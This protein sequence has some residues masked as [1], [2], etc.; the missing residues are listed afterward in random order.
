MKSYQFH[1]LLLLRSPAY[2]YKSYREAMLQSH[3]DQPYFRNALFLAAPGFYNQLEKQG[4]NIA[5]LKPKAIRTLFNYL[6]RI[7]FRT[8]PFGLF[9]GFAA[10]RWQTEE[11]EPSPISWTGRKLYL[12]DEVKYRQHPGN[13]DSGNL[14]LFANPS[15]YPSGSAFRY[16]KKTYN[17]EKNVLEYSIASM[18]GHELTNAVLDFCRQ[19]R[20]MA[21]ILGQFRQHAQEALTDYI[22]QLLDEDVLVSS[23]R[24]RVLHPSSP[25]QET[26]DD[27][28][29]LTTAISKGQ[30]SYYA[31]LKFEGVTGTAPLQFQQHLRQGLDALQVLCPDLAPDGLRKFRADFLKKF[32]ERSV[33]LMVALDPELGIGYRKLEQ[34]FIQPF[35]LD[36]LELP[37]QAATKHKELQWSRVHAMLLEK[38]QLSTDIRTAGIRLEEADLAGFDI[39]SQTIAPGFSALFRPM[40]NAVFIETAGGATATALL[41]RFGLFDE[42]VGNALQAISDNEVRNNP[43][44]VFAE[45]N[46]VQELHAAN[47]EQRKICYPYEI[48]VAS[49]P[50]GPAGGVIALS[51]LWVSVRG[52]RIL[53]WSEKLDREVIPRLSSAY[54]HSRS[55]LSVYRFLCDLQYQGLRTHFSFDL[56]HYF[57][58]LR[59][60]P[61]VTYKNAILSPATWMP[62]QAA[63]DVISAAPPKE[64][65]ALLGAYLES[66][67]LPVWIGLGRGD[68]QIV[69]DRTC[70]GD[71]ELLLE[72]LGKTNEPVFREFPFIEAGSWVSDRAGNRFL[73]Q[74]LGTLFTPEQ[75]YPAVAY[76]HDIHKALYDKQREDSNWIYLKV[77]CHPGNCFEILKTV[78]ALI[79]EKLCRDLLIS[80]FFYVI[81]QDPGY[82]L[83]LRM[84]SNSDRARASS[85]LLLEDAL[86]PLYQNGMIAQMQMDTYQKEL[87][88][89]G[90]GNMELVEAVFSA[91]TFWIMD[92][93]HYNLI[94]PEPEF[95]KVVASVSLIL[96]AFGLD[97]AA[98]QSFCGQV[99]ESLFEEFGGGKALILSLNEKYRTLRPRLAT[100]LAPVS[101][102]LQELATYQE[103]S[104]CIMALVHHN[105]LSLERPAEALCA[106]IVHMHL[107]R[108][109]SE[110]PR[111]QEMVCY[112]LLQ[113]QL[114]R[115]LH[116]Q[117][118]C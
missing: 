32:E 85:L 44:V 65:P 3:L 43:G 95:V 11:E 16:L 50:A 17:A 78:A 64:G 107:N 29:L 117:A 100:E 82:H 23:A 7:C 109:F 71:L 94:A 1:P 83:R 110:R 42:A 101:G 91:D 114:K 19:P 89:Y 26:M 5:S 33:P 99:F 14:Q 80:R 22:D 68:Q 108:L 15:I 10:V 87:E 25:E 76:R 97:T 2:P 79:T 28:T 98:Q 57:P 104:G 54:N 81:Y 35:L 115:R 40:D 47:V 72:A 69:Y 41:G 12:M 18:A 9:A 84:H 66:L 51:D 74:Y 63:L 75:R 116:Q 39:G 105:N 4:F 31:N 13:T 34:P 38:M 24:I 62:E 52:N 60:Y 90:A 118:A 92:G 27:R 37:A 21:A 49:F 30:Q 93:L 8:T 53:L 86:R 77:Y 45:I 36:G 58:H 55:H 70:P 88:R 113:Q 61:R 56:S 106:D 103:L 111:E 102:Q 67:E 20:T 73:P 6:N 46:C 112:F 48:A 96:E 59:F